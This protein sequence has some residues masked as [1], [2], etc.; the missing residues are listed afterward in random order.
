MPNDLSDQTGDCGRTQALCPL[1]AADLL[2]PHKLLH[3]HT[4]I[5]L[6][7]WYTTLY[8]TYLGC[9]H[10][11]DKHLNRHTQWH[12]TPPREAQRGTL[13]V[14]HMLRVQT[15]S[16][17]PHCCKYVASTS[18]F[19]SVCHWATEV[20]KG[21][22]VQIWCNSRNVWDIPFLW[23]HKLSYW[24]I[25]PAWCGS[26]DRRPKMCAPKRSQRNQNRPSFGVHRAVFCK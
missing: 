3:T 6:S 8:F 1:E 18:R 11:H 22:P 25:N 13:L 24:E 15:A 14:C 19:K 17:N 26:F 4:D 20:S 9:P 5:N 2:W 10:L 12:C 21:V 23:L 7:L 16:V